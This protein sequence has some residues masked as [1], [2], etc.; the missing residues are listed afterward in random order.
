MSYSMD[1]F[2]AMPFDDAKRALG[3]GEMPAMLEA[4]RMP[5]NGSTNPRTRSN[6]SLWRGDTDPWSGVAPHHRDVGS[7]EKLANWAVEDNST[8]GQDGRLGQ[9]QLLADWNEAGGGRRGSNS[10]WAS[11]APSSRSAEPQYPDSFTGKNRARHPVLT[12]KSAERPE[13]V[14]DGGHS[15]GANRARAR[16]GSD[17]QPTMPGGRSG[18]W[19]AGG[20]AGDGRGGGGGGGGARPARATAAP[21]H[22]IM[23]PVAD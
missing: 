21:A 14:G 16:H 9:N 1:D 4:P 11:S 3:T 5:M 12:D 13:Y 8:F 2:M 17:L 22:V 18:G 15:F 10:S 19:P 7:T 6:E 20:G 23:G